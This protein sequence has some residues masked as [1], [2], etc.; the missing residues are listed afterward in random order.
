[1]SVYHVTWMSQSHDAPNAIALLG[2]PGWSLSGQGV[3]ERLKASM[4]VCGDVFY[5]ETPE[6]RAVL[7]VLDTPQGPALCSF[8]ASDR[9]NHLSELPRVAPVAS[10]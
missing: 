4:D 7:R 9:S 6:G 1:M 3:I 2:G 10:S 5:L 8:V